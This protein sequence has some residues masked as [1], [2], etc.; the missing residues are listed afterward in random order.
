MVFCSRS[1]PPTC[2]TTRTPTA[3][4][5]SR[6]ESTR[7]VAQ[8]V[9]LDGNSFRDSHRVDKRKLVGDLGYGLVVMRGNWKVA[10]ARYHRTREFSGQSERPVFGSVTVTRRF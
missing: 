9:T 3:F 10:F 5:L 7:A 4:P 1:C 6:A 8:D 2:G